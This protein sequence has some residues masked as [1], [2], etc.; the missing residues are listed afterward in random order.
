LCVAHGCGFV[1]LDILA[2]ILGLCAQTLSRTPTRI[3]TQM[4]ILR[5]ASVC[6]GTFR[7]L[8][9]AFAYTGYGLATQKHTFSWGRG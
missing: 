9:I 6:R 1:L 2:A 5:S 8:R 3:E 7:A 4:P